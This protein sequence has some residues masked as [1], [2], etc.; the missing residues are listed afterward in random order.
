MLK[1]KGPSR[2]FHDRNLIANA[3]NRFDAKA[4]AVLE[5]LAEALYVNINGALS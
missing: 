5:A 4:F 1:H 3:P 2:S